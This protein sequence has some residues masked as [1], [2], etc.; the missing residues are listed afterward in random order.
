MTLPLLVAHI[1]PSEMNLCIRKDKRD[2]L[3]T[4]HAIYEAPC[5][6]R[7]LAYIGE[8]G[9]KF[10]TRLDQHKSEVEKVSSKIATRAD[11]KESLM[12]TYK[13]TIT[14]HMA[15]K[16]HVIDWEQAKVIGTEEDRYKDG[17]RRRLKSERGGARP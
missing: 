5:R 8:T 13:S 9:R 10:G 14:D 1:T 17:S 6:N 2:Q 11:R 4:T 3:N 12:N 15:E 16:N 7:N